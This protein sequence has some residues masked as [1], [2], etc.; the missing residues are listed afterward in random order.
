M[1]DGQPVPVEAGARLT[2]RAG[3]Y[4]IGVLNIQTGEK[5]SAHA[6]STNF[7]VLR[8]KRNVLRRSTIGMIATRR[9]PTTDAV[10]ANY[11]GGIDADF[12][13]FESM[14]FGGYYAKSNTPGL[15]SKDSSYRTRFD[16]RVT[17][18]A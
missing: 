5:V 11:V 4:S 7:S 14:S 13:F 1:S 10:A 3:P 9:A 16:Y 15:K 17:G 2:G 6:L 12:A 18:T 8:L